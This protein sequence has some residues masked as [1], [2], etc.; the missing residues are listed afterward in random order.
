MEYCDYCGSQA[1]HFGCFVGEKFSCDECK[2]VVIRTEALAAISRSAN[3]IASSSS[4]NLAVTGSMANMDEKYREIASKFN[5]RDCSVPLLRLKA[6]DF[7]STPKQNYQKCVQLRLIKEVM[8]TKSATKI[9]N[10][11]STNDENEIR[12][13]LKRTGKIDGFF[14]RISDSDSDIEIAPVKVGQSPKVHA[15]SSSDSD[16]ENKMMNNVNDTNTLNTQPTKPKS[17]STSNS[18]AE[19]KFSIS[20][21]E[22]N[23]PSVIMQNFFHKN[24]S[25]DPLTGKENEKPVK[26][27]AVVRPF[28]LPD[29]SFDQQNIQIKTENYPCEAFHQSSNGA[30]DDSSNKS[31]ITQRYD[32]MKNIPKKVEPSV[33]ILSYTSTKT[34]TTTTTTTKTESTIVHGSKSFGSSTD[35]IKRTPTKRKYRS[36]R[37]YFCDLSS[38]DDEIDEPK[39]KRK[40]PKQPK[41]NTSA[42]HVERPPNQSTIVNFFQRQLNQGI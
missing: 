1:A 24:S 39:P 3:G 25:D 19:R 9:A 31:S 36:V 37:S 38:S 35:A 22:P 32:Y 30:S 20:E 18:L 33:G 10:R 41:K 13:I 4:G 28:L 8:P 15:F 21:D 5:I 29:T 27:V 2:T 42:T 14:I 26:T 7:G 12:P 11:V 34:T 23:R 6:D 16:G 40:S 17:T